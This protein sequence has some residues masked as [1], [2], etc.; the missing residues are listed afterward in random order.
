MSFSVSL[1]TELAEIPAQSKDDLRALVYGFLLFSKEFSSSSIIAVSDS[2]TIITMISKGIS[3]LTSIRPEIIKITQ[4]N[5]KVSFKLSITDKAADVIAFFG[6]SINEPSRRI[7]RENLNKESSIPHFIRGAY[8]ACGLVADPNKIYRLEFLTV[9]MNLSN[10]LSALLGE[11]ISAPRF[12][13]RRGVYA[14]YYKES[15]AIEDL[16]TYCG[17]VH[18]S[19]EI[20]QI[21]VVK[22]VRN[23][24][25]RVTNCE[26]A[27]ISKVVNAAVTINN[28]IALILEKKSIEYL[29]EDL[30]ELA[31]LRY[32]NPEM[33]IRDLGERL[34]P[35]LSRSGVS[36]RLKRI[37]EAANKLR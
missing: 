12:T 36:H 2:H 22:N 35:P 5:G 18:S 7:L 6:H 20:M 31:M 34:N 23:K 16:L 21:K 32:N 26:T 10:D 4:K 19:L 14:L 13:V 8:L 27:N 17:A 15:A 3:R 11:Y 29:S 28:D 33:S 30:R 37:S 9:Y 25:N 1:K 24:I